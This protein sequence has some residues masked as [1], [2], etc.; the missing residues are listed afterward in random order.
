VGKPGRKIPLGRPR[1]RW[2]YNINM[3]LRWDGMDYIHPAEGRG[4][5]K[6]LV[7]TVTNLLVP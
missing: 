4:Q 2:K 1:R 5:W 6:A 3:E 7:S